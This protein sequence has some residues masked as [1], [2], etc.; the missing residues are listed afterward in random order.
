MSGTGSR[1]RGGGFTLPGRA[2]TGRAPWLWLSITLLAFALLRLSAMAPRLVETIYSRGLFPAIGQALNLLSGLA[3]FSLAE[4]I[5]WSLPL[6]A[7][8]WLAATARRV[9][10]ARRGE[11]LSLLGRRVAASVVALLAALSVIYAG[12]VVLWGL[13][14]GRRP[15]ADIA[16]LE[17]RPA[18][19]DGLAALCCSLIDRANALRVEVKENA[20]GVMT[21]DGT[22]AEALE[23]A[24]LGYDRAVAI[25]PA[26]GGRYAP[27]KGV[28]SS[29]LWSYTGI[30]GMYF[31]FTGE[32]NVNIAMPASSIPFAACHEMAH[33]RG[34]AREDEAN[35]IGYL[36]CRLHPDAD[37]RYSGTLAA[38]TEAMNQLYRHDPDRFT[39]LAARYSPAVGRD[40]GFESAFWQAHEGKVSEATNRVNDS[41]LKANGQKDGVRSYGRM[42]DL[43]LAEYRAERGKK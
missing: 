10:L 42:V 40:L 5:V 8:I 41:Y 20:T 17:V 29:G 28:L 12:F 38:A 22:V 25:H 24:Q 21:L 6:L 9:L 11:R 2:P 1:G 26:L 18:S 16:G 37:F 14:Y 15:F 31:P 36:A 13:N 39:E 35:Y 23:R 33:Q 30:E 27:S 3:P 7:I 32:A 43:L 19:V 34:F 4:A